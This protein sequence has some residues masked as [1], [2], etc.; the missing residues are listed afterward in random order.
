MVITRNGSKRQHEKLPQITPAQVFGKQDLTDQGYL[1]TKPERK[2]V[3]QRCCYW[4][5]TQGVNAGSG[6]ISILQRKAVRTQAGCSVDALTG[7][8]LQE[9]AEKTNMAPPQPLKRWPTPAG[10]SFLPALSPPPHYP[11]HSQSP[12]HGQTSEA[13]PASEV[14]TCCYSLCLE[15]SSPGLPEIDAVTFSISQV[16]NRCA[17]RLN[18]FHMNS[19]QSPGLQSGYAVP[20]SVSKHD[21]I[22][23]LSLYWHSNW[24]TPEPM[25]CLSQPHKDLGP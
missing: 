12:A 7:P 15:Y 3:H 17:E 2:S 16:G 18:T 21:S 9:E 8:C 1:F 23:N 6:N 22:S 24:F 4:L 11:P 10:S 14:C 5:A 25:A 19:R 13:L 20:A